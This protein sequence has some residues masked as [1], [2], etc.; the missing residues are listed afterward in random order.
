[1]HHQ[2]IIKRSAPC[3]RHLKLIDAL[4]FMELSTNFGIANIKTFKS[5]SIN[6]YLR[7]ITQPILSEKVYK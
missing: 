5:L 2:A 1:M 3:I 6:K 4:K 7:R